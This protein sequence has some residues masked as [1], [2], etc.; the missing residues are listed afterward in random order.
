MG[1]SVRL[2]DRPLSRLPSGTRSNAGSIC[3]FTVRLLSHHTTVFP[4][5]V[6]NRPGEYRLGSPAE[7]GVGIRSV[8]RSISPQGR[9]LPRQGQK[10]HL[11]LYGRGAQPTRDV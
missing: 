2:D 3:T 10:C 7:P 9:P 4:P 6:P 5:T 11:S 8:P 1:F